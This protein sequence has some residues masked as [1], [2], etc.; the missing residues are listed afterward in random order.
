MDYGGGG[1]GYS[2]KETAIDWS[3]KEPTDSVANY[4]ADY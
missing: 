3:K 2:R 4:Q 1:G